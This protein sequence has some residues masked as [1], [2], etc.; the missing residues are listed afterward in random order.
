MSAPSVS[1][2]PMPSQLNLLS[3]AQIRQGPQYQAPQNQISLKDD[4]LGALAQ[5][6]GLDKGMIAA[7]A[8]RLAAMNMQT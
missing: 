3:P 1:A 2:F 4:S 5:E 6:F 7:L 8:Q